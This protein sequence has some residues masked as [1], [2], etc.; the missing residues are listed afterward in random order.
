MAEIDE[1]RARVQRL[2]DTEAIRRLKARYLNA[3]DSQQ[4]ESARDCFA[5]GRSSSTWA[6]SGC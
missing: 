1:L 4:P 2:E 3:C 5:E 6:T